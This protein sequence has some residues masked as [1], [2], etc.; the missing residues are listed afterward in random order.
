[1]TGPF[2]VDAVT[3]F[4]DEIG[5]V[6]ISTFRDDLVLV[7]PAGLQVSG[8]THIEDQTYVHVTRAES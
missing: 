6:E 7:I 2:K 5:T 4:T 3:H 8:I 1:M